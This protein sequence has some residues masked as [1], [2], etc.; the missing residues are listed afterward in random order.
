M[1]GQS[2][3]DNGFEVAEQK[4]SVFRALTNPSYIS[5]TSHDPILTAFRLSKLLRKYGE[6]YRELSHEYDALD[7]VTRT[8]TVNLMSLCQTSA[9]V[10]L[11]LARKEGCR[12]FGSFPFARLVMAMDFEQKEF[13]A[14]VHVQ[15]TLESVW[16]GNWHDW[17][18][19]GT[20]HKFGLVFLRVL[21]L[22]WVLFTSL[23][24]PYSK[25]GRY[26]KL[27]VNRMLNYT[28]SYVLFL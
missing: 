21:L 13:V 25:S 22:P 28:A 26:Y 14:H 5:L 8:F 11:I 23:F 4:L 16:V 9:E 20:A 17:R 7:M 15:R 1:C 2:F 3:A 27:P 6:K 24:M 10:K 19:Y 18:W 12:F